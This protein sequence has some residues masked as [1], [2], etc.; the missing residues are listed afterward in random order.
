[1]RFGGPIV[2]GWSAESQQAAQQFVLTM[3]QNMDFCFVATA[4]YEGR[5]GSPLDRLRSFRD[6]ILLQSP[7][8]RRLAQRYYHDG[9]RLA[10][11]VREHP[12]V[13]PLLQPAFDL[14]S[15]VLGVASR[16]PLLRPL[17]DPLLNH[18]ALWLDDGTL[19]LPPDPGPDATLRSFRPQAW[20]V[21]M[22]WMFPNAQE[23]LPEESR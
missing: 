10:R 5:E 23:P 16:D 1:M 9:P 11:W 4:V 7:T 12:T 6:R 19:E 18:A 3:L 14:L 21:L 15:A 2:S 20:R 13:R 22:P 8:G 17:L